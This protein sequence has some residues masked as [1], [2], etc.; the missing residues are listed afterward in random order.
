MAAALL[1]ACFKLSQ[2]FGSYLVSVSGA[3]LSSRITPT[4]DGNLGVNIRLVVLRA[5]RVLAS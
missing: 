3:L 2:L 1:M 4:T 5:R